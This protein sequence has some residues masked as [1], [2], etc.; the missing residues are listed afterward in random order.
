MLE[1][2]KTNAMFNDITRLFKTGSSYIETRVTDGPT[3][4]RTKRR[5]DA[6]LLSLTIAHQQSNEN[7]KSIPTLRSNVRIE[8][9]KEIGDTGAF[10]KGYVQFT[11]STPRGVFS[12][13]EM[14]EATARL[15]Q[16]LVAG[17]QSSETT[18]SPGPFAAN[19]LS[20]PRLYNEE[21]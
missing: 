20:V 16:F 5:G 11:M 13:T 7:G 9:S 4:G 19:F 10:A 14:Q 21:P 12:S 3:N 2:R 1:R 15:V 6:G 18:G 17:E 8:V